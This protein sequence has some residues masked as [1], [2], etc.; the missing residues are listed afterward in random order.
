ML[1]LAWEKRHQK[2]PPILYHYT[3][4][5]GLLGML[6]SR[7]MWATNVRFMND[8]SELAYG[9]RLVREIFTEKAFVDRL[10]VNVKAP[11]AGFRDGIFGMLDDAEKN[12][13]HFA[14]SFCEN[15]NLLSQ[16]RGYG[17]S[18]GGFA[19][20]LETK[21]LGEFAA[22][23]V[24]NPHVK[25]GQIGVFLR[26][27]I[28]DQNAQESLVRDWVR[29]IV[30]SLAS[31]KPGVSAEPPETAAGQRLW[32]VVTRL[33]YECLVCF[34]HPGFQEE[35]EWRLIQQGRVGD[36]DVTKVDFRA[37]TG[38]LVSY[39]TLTF[40]PK[41]TAGS[42]ATLPLK[43]ITYGPTLDPQAAERALRGLLDS[44]GYAPYD[45]EIRPSGIPFA[46]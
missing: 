5:D 19:L 3:A 2:A 32:S 37:R 8:T 44:C 45:V 25:P 27:V 33:L 46:T 36:T 24:P 4:A 28:Y 43:A 35:R 6:Q 31:P 20:G 13:K 11:F 17:Q 41:R 29:A 42:I 12:T 7:Q 21:R 39:T 14:V 23:I 38:R 16:W 18:G 15:P 10:A 40:Q 30:K 34:K 26:R 9:I 1:W 22:E